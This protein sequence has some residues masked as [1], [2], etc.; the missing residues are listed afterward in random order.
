MLCP[1]DSDE[2]FVVSLHLPH[3]AYDNCAPQVICR[4]YLKHAPQLN[5]CAKSQ[6]WE[7]DSFIYGKSSLLSSVFKGRIFPLLHP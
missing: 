7:T 3:L 1:D 6:F 5:E 2:M 4:R